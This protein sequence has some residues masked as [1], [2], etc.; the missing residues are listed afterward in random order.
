MACYRAELALSPH[1]QLRLWDLQPSRGREPPGAGLE[2]AGELKGAVF[3]SELCGSGGQVV[4]APASLD[5]GEGCLGQR[6]VA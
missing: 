4:S 5:G 6:R 1:H 3:L 2:R